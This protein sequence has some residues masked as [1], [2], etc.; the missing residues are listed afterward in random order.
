MTALVRAL[1]VP[2]HREKARRTLSTPGD[3]VVRI[4][5]VVNEEER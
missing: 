3:L 2:M 1:P 5:P 4:R